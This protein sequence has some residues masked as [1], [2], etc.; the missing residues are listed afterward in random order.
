MNRIFYI[1]YFT[2]KNYFYGWVAVTPDFFL[3]INK[4][5][6]FFLSKKKLII[7]IYV[8]YSVDWMVSLL[9]KQNTIGS[10]DYFSNEII[11]YNF[12]KICWMG[13]PMRKFV[14]RILA[15][16]TD[17][18]I[19]LGLQFQTCFFPI[20]KL[21]VQFLINQ[22]QFKQNRFNNTTYSYKANFLQFVFHFIRN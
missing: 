14:L 19:R 8:I 13:S 4:H 7:L 1:Y 12:L 20:E 3:C 9:N 11:F 18:K 6:L 10:A 21:T 15:V 5:G 2:V 22:V 17:R 16:Q